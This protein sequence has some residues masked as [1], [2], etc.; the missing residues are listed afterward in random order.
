MRLR[1]HLYRIIFGTDTRAGRL[2]DLVLI[3]TILLS[4]IAVMLDSI[5]SINARYG[6]ELYYLEWFFTLLFTVEYGVRIYISEKPLR[7][8]FSFYGLVDLLSIIPTYVAILFPS[9][10]YLLII[11]LI[12]VL[13]VF[14]ILK[15][16]RYSNEAAMLLRAIRS[17]RRKILVFFSAVLV[18]STVFGSLMY[19][20]EGAEH[21][22]TSIPKSIY[23]T[24]VT[25]TTVGYGD[26]TPQTILGQLISVMAM[27]TGYSII[28]I[29]TG[30]VSAEL[31][32]EIRREKQQEIDSILCPGC[33]QDNHRK[34]ARFCHFCA[35]PLRGIIEI[36]K[37]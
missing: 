28:A 32:E 26:I 16:V 12:R 24:V 17:S 31:I 14:R 21:G 15:M 20:V 6:V 11:R 7:Y 22:F 36:G 19:V 8:I 3:Y 27:L 9:A 37:S 33:G 35:A 23:W 29:P 1:E 10:N 30:I 5:A 2:F 4:V 25:M 13:R 18:I 34:D